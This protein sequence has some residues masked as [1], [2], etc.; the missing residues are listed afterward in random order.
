[1]KQSIILVALLLAFSSIGCFRKTEPQFL[2][3]GQNASFEEKDISY[4]GTVKYEI[5]DAYI[6][7]TSG[8]EDINLNFIDEHAS[9]MYEN[10]SGKVEEVNRDG[11]L[12][13]DGS[14]G[15]GAKMYVLHVKFTNI[16]AEYKHYKEDGF[17][18]PYVFRADD[19]FMNFVNEKG[20]AVLSKNVN[21]YSNR[22]EGDHTW[23]TFELNPGETTEY[24][25]G[26]IAGSVYRDNG[27]NYYLDECT[28]LISSSMGGLEQSAVQ[29]QIK[30]KDK[31]Q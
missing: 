20:K 15:Y 17:H 8:N 18:T 10:S 31:R 25:I 5:T 2:Y 30:W 12:N 19:L 28:P 21:Y 26:Y 3:P 6:T 29:Y 23:S 22:Q 11:F 9:I 14:L 27:V 16:D 13:S 7:N 4:E 24:D 1:M